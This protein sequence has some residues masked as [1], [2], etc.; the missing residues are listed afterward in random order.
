MIGNMQ[1]CQ[2]YWAYFAWTLASRV[3]PANPAIRAARSRQSERKFSRYSQNHFCRIH[4]CG[5]ANFQNCD[6]K[7][8]FLRFQSCAPPGWSALARALTNP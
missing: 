4:F 8:A 2:G 3:P 7:N 6:F 1:D 5:F